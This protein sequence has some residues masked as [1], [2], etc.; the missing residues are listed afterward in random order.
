M[1]KVRIE[2]G[3]PYDVLIGGGLLGQAGQLVGKTISPCRAVLVT[4]SNVASLYADMLEERL[5]ASSFSVTRHVFPAGEG[6]KNME[7]LTGILEALA[8][9]GLTRTDLVVALGG[10][11]TGDMAGLA[12]SLYLR[13]VRYVQIPTTLLAAVD[14]SVGGKTAI[15][16]AG[17]KNIVGAFYQPSLVLCDT[18]TFHTL[19]PE[20]TRDGLSE[21]IKYGVICGASLFSRFE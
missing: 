6:H 21:S 13:G 8:D 19:T 7:T 4:D 11:V 5:T 1:R 20:I 12:A 16:F 10:G 3:T 17:R 9:T 2:A 15:D 18:D 14:S